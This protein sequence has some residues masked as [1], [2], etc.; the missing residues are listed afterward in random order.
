MDENHTLRSTSAT[1]IWLRFLESL[2]DSIFTPKTLCAT[3]MWLTP[4]SRRGTIKLRINA[5]FQKSSNEKMGTKIR[6]NIHFPSKLYPSNHIW[7]NYYVTIMDV[8]YT[9][10]LTPA[11]PI[12]LRFLICIIS[13]N[14]EGFFH[15]MRPKLQPEIDYPPP[16]KLI[17]PDK[18]RR[19]PLPPITHYS[20]DEMRPKLKWEIE[21][22]LH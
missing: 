15:D 19:S 18:S 16:H 10:K 3:L 7:C 17:L 14:N 21:P 6:L 8:I 12:W 4:I 2:R 20:P 11:T 22:L 9:L 13:L 1:S 5:F